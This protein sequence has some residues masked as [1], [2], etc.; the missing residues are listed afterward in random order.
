MWNK[1]SRFNKNQEV[2]GISSN[3]GIRT[4]LSKVPL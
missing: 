1:K 2:K 3:M 4:T